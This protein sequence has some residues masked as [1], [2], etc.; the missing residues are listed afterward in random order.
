MVQKTN[1]QFFKKSN[2]TETSKNGSSRFKDEKNLS[3]TSS[4]IRMFKLLFINSLVKKGKK[5]T[6][7]YFV[8]RLLY[9]IKLSIG[10]G[11]S[12]FDVLFYTFIR[13]RPLVT[14]RPFKAGP[15]LYHLPI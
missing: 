3:F 7:E 2:R 9:H 5:I 14:L 8:H 1:R 13:L 10:K 4:D 6:A 12:H 15:T 11:T